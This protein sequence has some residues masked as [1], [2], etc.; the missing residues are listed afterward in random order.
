MICTI[1]SGLSNT[2]LQTTDITKKCHGLK[3][4][5]D[6]GGDSTGKKNTDWKVKE[7]I[8]LDTQWFQKTN[9]LPKW[10]QIFNFQLLDTYQI[11]M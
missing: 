5:F 10:K 3:S 1:N 7:K 11:I 8:K 6:Q 2:F 4:S 9:T